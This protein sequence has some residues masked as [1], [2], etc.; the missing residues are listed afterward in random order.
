M[1][2]TGARSRRQARRIRTDGARLREPHE[3]VAQQVQALVLP[4]AG[5]EER[6]E[7]GLV[8][9]AGEHPADAGGLQPGQL[10]ADVGGAGA[11]GGPGRGS[12][13]RRGDRLARPTPGSGGGTGGAGHRGPWWAAGV[14]VG[15][16]TH[17]DPTTWCARSRG[18]A[19]LGLGT[20][21]RGLR[22]YPWRHVGAVRHPRPVPRP[23]HRGG[24]SGASGAPASG[25][26]GHRRR[27][28][29]RGAGAGGAGRA[30]D[31]GSGPGAPRHLHRRRG[32]VLRPGRRLPRRGHP[33][34]IGVVG[35]REPGRR[36]RPRAHPAVGGGRGRRR[37]LRGAT[38]GHHAC[39]PG[40]WG[41]AW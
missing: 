10:G 31:R 28:P 29:A 39:R 25:R 36:R 11:R 3:V 8:E 35:G 1:S 18:V 20:V 41:S 32:A 26:G 12:G 38:P 4:E 19:A 22:S 2:S 15:R 33:R 14:G 5:G 9:R 40:P 23:R 37:L 21:A 6:P 24:P 13:P 34:G 7:L 16:C 27:R 17:H 30:T